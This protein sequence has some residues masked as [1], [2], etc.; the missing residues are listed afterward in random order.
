MVAVFVVVELLECLWF[1]MVADGFA[2][3]LVVIKNIIQLEL[4]VCL[5]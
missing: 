4:T 3:K 2:Q 1:L 5:I